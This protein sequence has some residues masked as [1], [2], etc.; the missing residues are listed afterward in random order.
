MKISVGILLHVAVAFL[1][2]RLASHHTMP[3]T[4]AQS[5]RMSMLLLTPGGP[6]MRRRVSSPFRSRQ[7]SNGAAAQDFQLRQC[8]EIHSPRHNYFA[9]HLV[10]RHTRCG[11][12]IGPPGS[13]YERPTCSCRTFQETRWT[14]QHI[15]WLTDRL[16]SADLQQ[17]EECPRSPFEILSIFGLARVGAQL[18][19]PVQLQ[20]GWDVNGAMLAR[21][22]P[23]TLD[24][25]DERHQHR[26]D[27]PEESYEDT[28]DSKEEDLDHLETLV[29]RLAAMQDEVIGALL[30]ASDQDS[31]TA[32]L[33]HV[34]SNTRQMLDRLDSLRLGQEA[35]DEA[36]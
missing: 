9:F 26:Q 13:P 21:A 27:A 15:T 20:H 3:V 31:F 32:Q 17:D 30:Q 12:R 6:S 28:T 8:T 5:R 2:T 11:V 19:W 22:L 16:R 25:G 4:R 29:L 1:V 36:G 7:R 24:A 18:G 14:C 10:S 33:D 34:L 35:I 23:P